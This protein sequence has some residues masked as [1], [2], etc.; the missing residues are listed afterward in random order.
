MIVCKYVLQEHDALKAGLHYD[1][2]IQIPKQ[3]VLAS[4]A[5]PKHKL[6]INIGERVLAVRTNDHSHV[7]LY[8]DEMKIPVG[9]YGAGTIKTIEKGNF[10][11]EGWSDR[12]I[13]F[14]CKDKL[15][16]GRFALIKFDGKKKND[17]MNLWMF[18]KIKEKEKYAK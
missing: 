3:R 17:E 11:V 9:N 12:Y 18:I 14:N 15:I 1:L 2:R 16:N 13:T 7:W 6:P 10:E 5:L 8:T 4:W